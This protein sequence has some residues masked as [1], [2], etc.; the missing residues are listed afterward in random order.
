LKNEIFKRGFDTMFINKD[1]R[2]C[3]MTYLARGLMFESEEKAYAFAIGARCCG[4][5]TL[6]TLV[7][8]AFGDYVG[9]FEA[10]ELVQKKGN[11]NEK[12]R[13]FSFMSNFDRVPLMFSQEVDFDASKGEK[14]N[15]NTL[16]KI[17]GGGRDSITTRGVFEKEK[18]FKPVSRMIM[19]ANSMPQIEPRDALETLLLFAFECKFVSKIGPEEEAKNAEGR[20]KYI[21]KDPKINDFYDREDVAMETFH[22]ILDSYRDSEDY[23]TQDVKDEATTCDVVV[24]PKDAFMDLLKFTKNKNDMMTMKQLFSLAIEEDIKVS[25]TDIKQMLKPIAVFRQQLST[26]YNRAAGFV[27]V[28]TK[29]DAV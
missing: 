19:C 29:R 9:E 16:K 18:T 25:A 13:Q 20:F 4:K 5:G 23:V 17:A 28:V 2:D 26:K 1:T 10:S 15:G 6:Q 27:G 21:L 14:L 12:S 8:N 11:T 7:K 3:L 22:I 24:D